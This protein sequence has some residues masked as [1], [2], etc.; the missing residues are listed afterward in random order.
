MEKEFI[1]DEKIISNLTIEKQYLC[2]E[3][4]KNVIIFGIVYRSRL[5]RVTELIKELYDSGV[6][7]TDKTYLEILSEKYRG[8]LQEIIKLRN[9]VVDGN[10]LFSHYDFINMRE[11]LRNLKEYSLEIV[12]QYSKSTDKGV[13]E[14]DLLADLIG[15]I[16][17]QICI[18]CKYYSEYAQ[19]KKE[20]IDNFNRKKAK[21]DKLDTFGKISA[22]FDGE[23]RELSRAAKLKEYYDIKKH[24]THFAGY[25]SNPDQYDTFLN[26]KK[27]NTLSLTK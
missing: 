11:G 19:N 4:Y 18:D 17:K 15:E 25:I 7:G 8:I 26:S 2:N 1:L 16:E 23:K 13:D 9:F 12:S 5:E 3:F 10:M 14:L 24:I 27:S 6:F 22:I 20:A 21:Y